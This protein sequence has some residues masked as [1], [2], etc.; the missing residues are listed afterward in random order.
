MIFPSKVTRPV[1]SLVYISSR[2]L[3]ALNQSAMSIDDIWEKVNEDMDK[4]IS[5][6]KVILGLNFLFLIDRIERED[7][8]IRIKLS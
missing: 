1:D 5:L 4:K 6:K 8:I 7:E 3:K 2:I